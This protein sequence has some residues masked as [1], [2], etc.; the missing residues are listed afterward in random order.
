MRWLIIYRLCTTT[1]ISPSLKRRREEKRE[2]TILDSSIIQYALLL[3]VLKFEFIA[4]FIII[5]LI[6]TN[7]PVWRIIIFTVAKGNRIVRP[8]PKSRQNPWSL[9]FSCPHNRK[10]MGPLKLTDP[11][12]MEHFRPFF[13]KDSWSTRVNYLI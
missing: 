8:Q 2:M 6:V 11:W 13:K 9:S 4:I 5:F 12:A 7:P 10:K 3:K 1:K